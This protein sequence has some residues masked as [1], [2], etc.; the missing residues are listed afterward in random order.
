MRPSNGRGSL[1]GTVKLAR[2]GLTMVMLHHGCQS[3]DEFVHCTDPGLEQ[4][5]IDVTFRWINWHVASCS[6]PRTRFDVLFANVCAGFIRAATEF[7]ENGAFGK[8]FVCMGDT[9]VCPCMF[10][11]PGPHRCPHR[12]KRLLGGGIIFEA[13]LGCSLGSP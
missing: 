10:T 8:G 13:F 4:G 2:A 6:F 5:R 1:V 12:R 9:L 11:Q 3:Q 7:V